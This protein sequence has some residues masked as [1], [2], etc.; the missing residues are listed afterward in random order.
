MALLANMPSNRRPLFYWFKSSPY[1]YTY[2]HSIVYVYRFALNAM[3]VVCARSQIAG[4]GPCILLSVIVLRRREPLIHVD[5]CTI[6]SG[7]EGPF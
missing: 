2:I 1:I 4:G 7:L 3:S 5:I 6:G